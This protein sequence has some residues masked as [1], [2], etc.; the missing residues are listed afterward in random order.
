MTEQKPALFR[1]KLEL[2]I[3]TESEEV[4]ARAKQVVSAHYLTSQHLTSEKMTGDKAGEL[5]KAVVVL[6]AQEKDESLKDFA[7]RIDQ[8]LLLCP[9][10]RLV[11]VMSGSFSRENLEG[12][13]NPRVTAI[14]QAE[15]FSTLKFAYLCV[16][17]CRSQ[18]FEVQ[19]NDFFPMTTILHPCFVRLSLNQRYLAVISS[20]SVLSENRVQRIEAHKQLYI[21]VSD[22]PKYYE[23]IT[24]FYDSSG[25]ALKKK[26]RALFLS[27]YYY[28]L[29]LNDNILFD[30]KSA[31]E[32]QTEETFEG[33]K[34]LAEALFEV[35]KTKE[36]LWDVFREAHDNEIGVFWR[37]PWIAVYAA[38]MAVKSGIGDPMVV[39]VS[40]LVMDVGLYDLDEE[41]TRQYLMSDNKK[42]DERMMAA[43]QKH[44]LLSLNRALIKK[45]PIDEA[46]KSV[47]VCTH[48]KANE[49]G[50]P[51]Q[52]PQAHLP[53]EAQL[54]MF[55]ESIDQEVLT[56]MKKNGV[57]FRFLKEKLWESEK[58]TGQNF[59]PDFLSSIAEALL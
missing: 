49:T 28:S 31:P 40:G 55:A 3:L 22:S 6:M 52:V 13:Q 58:A 30:F 37:A 44:P 57:G 8:A 59:S 27:I 51:N 7:Q 34:K 14:S 35:M 23:Y 26:A 54:L 17:H 48:E 53:V 45:V 24:N 16:Y 12:T 1:H 15:F 19:L 46:M 32:T 25:A 39:L 20:Q 47:I 10:S 21:R 2:L 11:A 18:F 42:F 9:R 43:F 41:T 29:A 50:F 5:N 56:T 33:L 36:D 38:L 4:L